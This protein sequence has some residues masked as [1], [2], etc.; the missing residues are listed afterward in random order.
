MQKI[1]K[2]KYKPVSQR[3]WLHDSI[4]STMMPV[5]SADCNNY[6]TAGES[7]RFLLAFHPFSSSARL[8]TDPASAAVS[9]A[10]GTVICCSWLY[11][12][13][14]RSLTELRQYRTIAAAQDLIWMS[15]TNR[16][17]NKSECGVP[18][19][20]DRWQGREV[21]YRECSPNN[22]HHDTSI[23]NYRNITEKSSEKEYHASVDVAEGG[24]TRL[25]IWS[26]DFRFTWMWLLASLRL[27]VL[28]QISLRDLKQPKL[29]IFVDP[30]LKSQGVPLNFSPIFCV[31][32]IN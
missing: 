9:K 14:T 6:A 32:C 10:I 22:E 23:T 2:K 5:L 8:L 26:S 15:I 19:M 3:N 7:Y 31:S 1:S 29:G 20:A 11:R 24:S 12:Q 25:R 21:E 28:M 4:N 17:V 27:S 30:S 13:S 16:W 18:N